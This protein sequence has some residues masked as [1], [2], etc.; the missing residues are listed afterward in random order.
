M[1]YTVGL[2]ELHIET[3]AKIKKNWGWRGTRDDSV[4]K[5]IYSAYVRPGFSS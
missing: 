1:V 3:L 4:V 5:S 2:P